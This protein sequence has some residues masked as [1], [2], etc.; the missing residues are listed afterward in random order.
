M[1]DCQTNPNFSILLPTRNRVDK[2]TDAIHSLYSKAKYKEKVEFCIKIDDDD[3]ETI[4]YIKNLS[5]FINIKYDISPREGGYADLYK[6]FNKCCEISTG[7]W[8][9]LFNDDGR[10]LTEHWDKIL[11]EINPFEV[12]G[13]KGTKDICLLSPS[14]KHKNASFIYPILKRST[15]EIL[16]HF[17]NGFYSDDYIYKVMSPLDAA[18]YVEKVLVSEIS[19]TMIDQVYEEGRHAYKT[20]CF[21]LIN[22]ALKN[23]ETDIYKLISHMQNQTQ[24]SY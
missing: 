4:N 1:A 23:I 10:M 11:L 20:D 13:W 18:I 6:F 24:D 3:T 8:L 16:G 5:K 19:E 15:Y 7:N 12:K 21:K 14:I 2:L 22:D 9:F 17:S